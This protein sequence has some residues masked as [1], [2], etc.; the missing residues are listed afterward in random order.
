MALVWMAFQSPDRTRNQLTTNLVAIAHNFGCRAALSMLSRLGAPWSAS[1][2]FLISGFNESVPMLPE[3][4]DVLDSDLDKDRIIR[5]FDQRVS[6]FATG[7]TILPARCSRRLAE[8]PDT[9]I[10][11]VPES[12]YCLA[13][14]GYHR[15]PVL[16]S[17]IADVLVGVPYEWNQVDILRGGTK[18]ESF[19]GRWHLPF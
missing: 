1:A 3:L 4:D 17:L 5:G 13:S 11:E 15:F 12:T 2:L 18:T 10:C 6:V 8:Q 7:D 19:L 16:L 9:A 14:E